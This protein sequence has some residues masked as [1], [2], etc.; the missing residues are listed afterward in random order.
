MRLGELVWPDNK[1]LQSFR[2]VSLR[3]SFS[4]ARKHVEFT[5]PTHKADTTFDGSKIL[6]LATDDDDCPVSIMLNYV[7]ERDKRFPAL[8]HLW[9][10]SD[11]SIP[12]RSWFLR[13]LRIFFS[14]NVGGHSIRSGGAT[15]LAQMGTPLHL[16]QATGRWASET[17][18][19]YI[20]NHPVLLTAL[21]FSKGSE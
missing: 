4:G 21:L 14:D 15:F 11:G 1:S 18:R 2:K 7:A 9:V 17:F 19:I 5:L 20:R 8:P 13:R 6:V 3:S 16:I 12:T 10:K